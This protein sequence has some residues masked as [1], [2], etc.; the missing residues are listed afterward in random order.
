MS[1]NRFKGFN[2]EEPSS[3]RV[4]IVLDKGNDPYYGEMSTAK[5]N[6]IDLISRKIPDTGIGGVLKGLY[7]GTDDTVFGLLPSGNY[8]SIT[9]ESK[10]GETLSFGADP[11]MALKG[12]RY[13]VSG[14]TPISRLIANNVPPFK[15]E[16]KMGG[17]KRALINPKVFKESVIDD[18]PQ[19][20]P[21]VFGEDRLFAWRTKLGLGKPNFKYSQ[22]LDPSG[23]H[24]Y[25]TNK[26]WLQN[27]PVVKVMGDG[28]KIYG[29]KKQYAYTVNNFVKNNPI[30]EIWNK[31]GTHMEDG[32]KY[33]HYKNPDDYFREV[34]S[35]GLHSL[36]GNYDVKRKMKG[37][38]DLGGVY[39]ED[40]YDNWDFA[41]NRSLLSY[42]KD[43]KSNLSEAPVFLQR[44]LAEALL[45][46]LE[47]KGTAKKVYRKPGPRSVY[48][49]GYYIREDF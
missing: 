45:K 7:R 32:K 27:P 25:Q 39:K 28:T 24:R 48:D 29:D 15:Y 26:F 31:F 16:N 47:F 14:G 17:I 11:Y 13:A 46:P 12:A 9:P 6:L 49:E 41:R 4:E 20:A 35:E 23:Y 3:S 37:S 19:W 33:Y 5:P 44:S 2:V 22:A 43:V 21:Q 38:K 30:D 8:E 40:Y 1:Q 10:F 42:L 34:D 18:I 36:F